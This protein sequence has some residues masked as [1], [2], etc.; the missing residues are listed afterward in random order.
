MKVTIELTA[1]PAVYPRR[2][3]KSEIDKNI[4]VLQKVMNLEPLLAVDVNHLVDT[5]SIL[6]SIR[7]QLPDA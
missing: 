7:K 3:T 5:L 2:P 4:V 1:G 6:R